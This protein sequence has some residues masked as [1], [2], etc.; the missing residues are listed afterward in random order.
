MKARSGTYGWISILVA[1]ILGA[2]LLGGCDADEKPV[3]RLSVVPEEV[4]LGYPGSVDLQF[5]WE[6]ETDLEGAE[7]PVYVFVHLLD[8]SGS[9]VRTFDHRFPGTWRPGKAVER[10]VRLYQSLL[11]PAL[12]PG[13]YSL[14]AGLYDLSGL[15]WPLKTAG[16]AAAKKEYRVAKVVVPE[17]SEGWATFDF[18]DGWSRVESGSDLQVLGR[19][20]IARRGR[21]EIREGSTGGTLWL[22]LTIPKIRPGV[23]SLVLDEGQSEPQITITGSC[24]EVGACCAG[25]GRHLVAL[26]VMPP[27]DATASE[28]CLIDVETNFTVTDEA[29]GLRTSVFLNSLSWAPESPPAP[30]VSS[31]AP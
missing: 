25:V 12:Q 13:S 11:G 28:S 24:G 20:Y 18:G 27:E 22:D 15:R 10:N 21:L 30:A 16:E 17:A 4:V 6:P 19:R 9:V 26:P 2:G 7:E 14:S 5:Q 29:S 8:A 23:Q 1:G 3:G 31:E